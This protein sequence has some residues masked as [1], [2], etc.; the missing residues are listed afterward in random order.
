MRGIDV[1]S[2]MVDVDFATWGR[3]ELSA[4]DLVDAGVRHDYV[5]ADL[6][7]I[8]HDDLADSIAVEAR[9]IDPGVAW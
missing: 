9:R 1:R 2:R 3:V 6:E 4:A 7:P 5:A 8:L